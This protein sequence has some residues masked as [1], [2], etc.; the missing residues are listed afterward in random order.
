MDFDSASPS[1]VKSVKQRDLLN[2]WLRLHHDNPLPALAAYTPDRLSEEERDLVYYKVFATENGPRFMI[3]SEGARLAQGYG[4]I[5][6]GNKG[7]WLDEFLSPELVPVV[8]PVYQECVVRRLPVY[9]ITHIQ[10]V[11]GQTIDYERIALP[12]FE[13]GAVSDILMSAKLIS[14]ASRFELNNLFRVREKLPVP[15]IR[16]VIDRDLALSPPQRQRAIAE[17]QID[18]E[19]VEL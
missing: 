18:S 5:N 3:N 2:A 15:A 12:F 6:A 13:G 8:L 17:S 1:V 4:R 19:I 16:A 9:T 10:D 11:R 14:E 7:T